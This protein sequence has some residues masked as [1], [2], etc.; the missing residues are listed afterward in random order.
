M[1]KGSQFVRIQLAVMISI[2]T[3]ELHF[4]ESEYLL[5]GHRL[6][7]RYRSHIVLDCH[8]NLRPHTGHVK[9]GNRAIAIPWTAIITRRHKNWCK[10]EPISASQ[11][12]HRLRHFYFGFAILA[13]CQRTSPDQAAPPI[14]RPAPH[15]K[16]EQSGSSSRRGIKPQRSPSALP[17]FLPQTAAPAGAIRSGSWWLPTAVRT[18]PPRQLETRSALS[19]KSWKS[20]PVPRKPLIRSAQP[21]SWN[22]FTG[23][24]A[25]RCY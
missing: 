23:Y 6:G 17:V 10:D 4:E 9:R 18:T 22:I 19:V 11:S 15:Q 12:A 24:R 3:R 7:C 1:H 21:S 8:E 5:L 13:A 20:A 25:T 14:L 2:R 16:S